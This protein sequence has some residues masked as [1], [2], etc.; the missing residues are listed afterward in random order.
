MTD[1]LGP[2]LTIADRQA[3]VQAIHASP[4]QLVLAVAGGGNACITDLLD[5][6]GA[7]ATVLEVCVPYAHRALH[8]L[9]ANAPAPV[10]AGAGLV[11]AAT[12]EA[13]AA[14]SLVRARHLAEPGTPV[15]GVACTAALVSDRPKRGEHR[16]HVATA[17]DQGA[18]G[19]YVQLDKGA[20]DR[21][22]EDRVVAD[23]LL[24][25]IATACGIR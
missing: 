19:R 24:A 16:A 12:A 25:A 21:R 15:I 23:A 22:G 17:S 5:V 18:V 7:S 10:A 11:T 2:A 3:L 8:E 14:A 13:M 20:L 4:A 1:G 9:L 6:P